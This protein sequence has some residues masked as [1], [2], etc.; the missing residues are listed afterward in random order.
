MDHAKM[1]SPLMSSGLDMVKD[2][3]T[4]MLVTSPYF[5]DQIIKTNIQN[6][7]NQM[8]GITHFFAKILYGKKS[9]EWDR[10]RL[11]SQGKEAEEYI[12]DHLLMP[13]FKGNKLSPNDEKEVNKKS[14]DLVKKAIKNFN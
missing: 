11:T 7:I 2:Q 13:I 12:R 6:Q 14:E 9:L 10:V 1:D 5:G 8:N 4:K 3:I